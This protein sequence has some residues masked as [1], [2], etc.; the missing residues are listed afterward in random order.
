VQNEH[1][2]ASEKKTLF[3][4]DGEKSEKRGH[5]QLAGQLAGKL[6]ERGSLCASCTTRCHCS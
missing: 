4:S 6:V 2:A 1:K 3:F 5:D